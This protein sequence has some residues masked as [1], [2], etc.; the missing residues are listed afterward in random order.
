[1]NVAEVMW[2]GWPDVIAEATAQ[3]ERAKCGRQRSFH[4]AGEAD[5]WGEA[6]AP[7]AGDA[8]DVVMGAGASDGSGAV[9]GSGASEAGGG[10]D[11]SVSC[12]G[13]G[14]SS[15]DEPRIADPL[16]AICPSC[17]PGFFPDAATATAG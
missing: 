15:F 5:A 9:V 7:G 16:L 4:G 14:A 10:R 1:M 3:E 13:S 8:S 11:T 12:D 2:C 17:A 6:D